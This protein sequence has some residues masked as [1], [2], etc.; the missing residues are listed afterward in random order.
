MGGNNV[1][2]SIIIKIIFISL[3]LIACG[4]N[5]GGGGNSNRSSE[6]SKVRQFELGATHTCAVLETGKLTCWGNNTYGQLGTN[7]R[8]SSTTP[9]EVALGERAR[10]VDAGDHHTCAILDDGS[11]ACW[12]R[13]NHGQLG[14]GDKLD[15][16]KLAFVDLGTG[17][18]AKAVSAGFR[19]TCAILDDDSVLCWGKGSD[20][21][22]GNSAN[23]DSNTPVSVTLGSNTAKQIS[24]GAN[25][26]CA[27]LDDDSVVCW[28]S[29]A[30][31]QLGVGDLLNKN[32][33]TKVNLG[34]NRTAIGI[35]TGYISTCALLDDKS[36][37]CWGSNSTRHLGDGN[38]PNSNTPVAVDLGDNGARS[39]HSGG[40]HSCALMDDNSVKCWGYNGFGQLGDETIIDKYTPIDLDLGSGTV[41]GLGVAGDSSCALFSDGSLACWGRNYIGQLGTGQEPFI[42]T[43]Q[44][45]DTGDEIIT[46]IV[47][48]IGHSCALFEDSNGNAALKCWGDNGNAQLGVGDKAKRISPT[49]I[50]Q[51]ASATAVS[52]GDR[53]VCAIVGTSLRCWGE[54]G[55]GQLGIGSN[56]DAIIPTAVN[57]GN[58]KSA[59]AVSLGSGHTCA[60]LNDDKV[61]CWG[62]GTNG[63]LGNNASND[64]NTPVAVTLG[65][66]TAKK[67]SLGGNH[68]CAIFNNDKIYCWGE[69]F[70][71]KLGRGSTTDSNVPVAVTLDTSRTATAISAGW[72]HTCA[73]LD[74]GTLVCWGINQYGQLGLGVGDRM[75][76]SSPVAVD[77]GSDRSAI[78]IHA[79]G[80]HTCAI[81]D[82]NS[83][84]CWGRNHLGQLGDGTTTYRTA[85]VMVDLGASRTTTAMG[86]GTNHTCA[87]L[88]DKSIV[89]W[90]NNDS[91]QTGLP[92]VHRG[93]Q[94]GEMGENLL[95]VDFGRD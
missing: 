25:H 64:S 37:K 62:V 92:T 15:K 32:Q 46:A 42:V 75:N 95:F 57:L 74:N 45:V 41:T 56:S 85:P 84:A 65:S 73:I 21:Q 20:G 52:S 82:D 93:D 70:G 60:I 33:P 79:Q 50:P 6:L 67:I 91:A 61:V 86:G 43:P 58:G 7:D 8:I 3:F 34:T 31:G 76:R 53:H 4:D 18:S 72:H 68:T 78:A 49:N 81:L 59:K 88:D 66:N 36:I 5:D 16:T 11:L 29:N 77:L 30:L 35:G 55:S 87:I 13:N 80:N 26:S 23:N 94:P 10:T 1:N 71:G 24:V 38:N 9:V 27:I 28:G 14:V 48:G 54:N 47:G 39:L 12:G 17:K 2:G 83:L 69:G 51:V 63:R 19:H 89:C 40:H 44:A 22:L 90:G